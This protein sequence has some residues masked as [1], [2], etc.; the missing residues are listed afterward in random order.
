MALPRRARDALLLAALLAVPAL[1]LRAGTRAPSELTW[2]D[3]L[4]LRGSAPVQGV[5]TRSSSWVGDLWRRYVAL[6]DVQQ[7]NSRLGDENARLR[8]EL[9]R[10]Q[11]LTQRAGEMERLLGLRK[12]V[13]SETLVARVV[14]VETSPFYRVIRVKLDRGADEVRPGM[15]VVV[16]AG[17]VGSVRRVFGAYC[18]VLLAVDPESS[19]DV[20]APR[21]GAQGTLRGIAGEYRY[22]ARMLRTD[23]VREGEEIVTSGNDGTYPRDL[24]IGVVS[25]VVQPEAGLWKDAEITPSVDFARLRE[26]VVVLAP[27][28]PPDPEAGKRVTVPHRGLGTPR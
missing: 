14:G 15:P 16:S 18:D 26:V 20:V 19:I 23:E 10:A 13:P 11:L 2:V 25:K 24:A 8:R 27:P 28:P 6:I 17:V 5:I 7:E 22:R 3:R 21:T 1:V 12:T 4:V 9:A